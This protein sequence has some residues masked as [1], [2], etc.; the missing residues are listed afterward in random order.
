MSRIIK[1]TDHRILKKL[2]MCFCNWR[3]LLHCIIW[4]WFTSPRPLS[5]YLYLKQKKKKLKIYIG[6]RTQRIA[7][8]E[9]TSPPVHTEPE[10][11]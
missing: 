1:S 7:I 10:N 8:T 3:L 6:K 2:T 4:H 11:S 9:L 5:L